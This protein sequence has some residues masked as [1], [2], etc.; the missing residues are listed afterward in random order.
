[1]RNVLKPTLKSLK[2]PWNK[3]EVL[4]SL[5]QVWKNLRILE[6]LKNIDASKIQVWK[7]VKP[8]FEIRTES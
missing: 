4:K 1:M 7:N 5:N 8:I 2:E 6:S 3:F